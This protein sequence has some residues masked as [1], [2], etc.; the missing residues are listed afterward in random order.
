MDYTQP[1][2]LRC[3]EFKYLEHKFCQR[4]GCGNFDHENINA[5]LILDC[6]KLVN[7]DNPTFYQLIAN[8][9]IL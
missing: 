7:N 4:S 9:G 1:N 3:I 6:C 8:Q 5:L 2:F